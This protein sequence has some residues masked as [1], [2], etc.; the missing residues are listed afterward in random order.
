MPLPSKMDFCEFC[1]GWTGKHSKLDDKS[2]VLATVA[3]EPNTIATEE[4]WKRVP[5]PWEL[6]QPTTRIVAHCLLGPTNSDELK[7]QAARA[8]EC[9]YWR[10]AETM[11]TRALLLSRSVVRLS[12]MAEEPIPEPSFS[13]GIEN[14]AELEAMRADILSTKN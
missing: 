11:D 4:K 1:V 9:L 2:C 8:A 10:A 14:M 3:A 13:G 6:F 5:L 7:T 12:Q